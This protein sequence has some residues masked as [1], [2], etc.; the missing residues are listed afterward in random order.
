MGA[1]ELV[2]GGELSLAGVEALAVA[3]QDLLPQRGELLAQRRVL[4]GGLGRRGLV[5]TGDD[6]LGRVHLLAH[7]Y[8]GARA[9]CHGRSGGRPSVVS[10]VLL[11]SVVL[12]Y[13]AVLRLS[14]PY[15]VVVRYEVVRW[16]V[17]VLTITMV[18]PVVSSWGEVVLGQP[19]VL[20]QLVT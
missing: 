2:S 11:P 17:V 9:G 7:L 19:H 18:G 10:V 12:P 4:L 14:P 5:G 8:R 3:A 20:Q 16:V 15:S 13:A 6:A 1:G